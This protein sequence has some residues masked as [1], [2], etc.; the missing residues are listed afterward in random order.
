M[1]STDEKMMGK[2]LFCLPRRLFVMLLAAIALLHGVTGLVHTLLIKELP[3]EQ[4]AAAWQS[5]DHCVGHSCHDVLTCKGT[6][7]ASFHTREVLELIGNTVFGYWG[8]LGA[9]HGYTKDLQWFSQYL[10]GFP[11]FLFLLFLWDGAYCVVCGEYPL[12]VIDEALLWKL[13]NIPVK[14]ADKVGLTEAMVAY[15]VGFTNRL[16]GRNVFLLYTVWEACWGFFLAYLANQVRLH[17]QFTSS[18]LLGLG[19]TYD[20]GDWRESVALARSRKVLAGGYQG[21]VSSDPVIVL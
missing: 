7:Q 1:G 2:S 20:I 5:N 12:N 10:F 9:L 17:A 4:G 16:V 13:P 8:L 15:P 11:L 21:M 19:A 3:G 14:E 6:R 18:G